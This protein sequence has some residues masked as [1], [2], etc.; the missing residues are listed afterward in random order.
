MAGITLAQ[1]Q[2]QL[3]KYLDAETSVLAGQS[4]E[5]AGRKLTRANLDFIQKG[6][7]LWDGRVKNLS[8]KAAGRTRAVS[9]RPGW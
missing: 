4:Y 1:A 3:Q 9:V 8:N 7:D 5:I 2:S 6:I